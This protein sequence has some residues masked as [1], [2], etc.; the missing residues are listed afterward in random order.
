M[1]VLYIYIYIYIYIYLYIHIYIY[2]CIYILYIYIED[3]DIKE[4]E[5]LGKEPSE[6][7]EV[8]VRAA[9]TK[10]VEAGVQRARLI[11]SYISSANHWRT[12]YKSDIPDNIADVLWMTVKPYFG[13]TEMQQEPCLHPCAGDSPGVR[14]QKRQSLGEI[15]AILKEIGS[16]ED[17]IRDLCAGPDFTNVK[18][19]SESFATKCNSAASRKTIFV[20]KLRN[21]T[22]LAPRRRDE[23]DEHGEPD[24]EPAEGY[25]TVTTLPKPTYGLPQLPADLVYELFFGWGGGGEIGKKKDVFACF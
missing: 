25:S 2:I 11:R 5:A 24:V 9:A 3:D 17:A 23:H 22:E 8:R 18:L 20:N 14:H 19:V 21:K 13:G 10:I 6:G 4:D 1:C 12:K 16:V 7:K 15:T